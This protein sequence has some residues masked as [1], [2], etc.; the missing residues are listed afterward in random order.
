MKCW[1][2]I[3]IGEKKLEILVD[4]PFVPIVGMYIGYDWQVKVTR[5]NYA[6]GDD[7]FHCETEWPTEDV[8]Y[9][10]VAC[11]VADGWVGVLD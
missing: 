2:G 3:K 9:D 5:V 11:L 10:P 1:L 4:L 8:D 6:V 7:T